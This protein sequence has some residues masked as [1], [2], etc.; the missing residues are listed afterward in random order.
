MERLAAN[1][2]QDQ[3]VAIAEQ[4]MHG[5]ESAEHRRADTRQ[6]SN[7][8]TAVHSE[9]CGTK[10]GQPD[11]AN[12]EASDDEAENGKTERSLTEE[13]VE[14]ESPPLIDEQEGAEQVQYDDGA[15]PCQDDRGDERPAGASFGTGRNRHAG[16]G[17]SYSATI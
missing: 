11:E 5:A 10:R 3:R 9:T 2:V 12:C 13:S 1:Q 15:G 7:D 4:G 6:E 17:G 14:M 8:V 16:A